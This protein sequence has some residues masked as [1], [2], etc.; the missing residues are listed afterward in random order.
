MNQ[1]FH[2]S[3]F[4]MMFMLGWLSL[5]TNVQAARHSCHCDCMQG[6]RVETL[7]NGKQ[8]WSSSTRISTFFVPTCD[9]CISSSCPHFKDIDT[10]DCETMCTTTHD[11]GLWQCIKNWWN[12]PEDDAD[13]TTHPILERS[14]VKANL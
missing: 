2:K 1:T 12:P 4:M 5:T 8:V 14:L 11:P 13:L 3:S 10:D 6:L 7:V 9:D